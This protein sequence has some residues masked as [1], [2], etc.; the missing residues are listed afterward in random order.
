MAAAWCQ[1][2][3]SRVAAQSAAKVALH[4]DMKAREQSLPREQQ[5]DVIINGSVD[6][7]VEFIL[8]RKPVRAAHASYLLARGAL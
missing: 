6:E 5:L 1:N 4:H 7:V 3:P 8:A 2:H